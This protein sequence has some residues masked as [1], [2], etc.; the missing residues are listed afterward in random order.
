MNKSILLYGWFVLAAVVL[1]GSAGSNPAYAQAAGEGEN[2][3]QQQRLIDEKL[4]K[5]RKELA[6]VNSLLDWQWGGWLEYYIFHFDDGIQ[7]QRVYQ[8]PGLS[9]WTRLNVDNGAHQFFVRMKFNFEYFNPG[10]EYKRQQDWIGPNLDRG[11]YQID[12]GKAFRLTQPDDPF[13][14][15]VRIGRQDVMFGTGY[16]LDLPLDAVRFD[17]KLRDLTI[18]GLFAKTIGSYPN[19]D[20]SDPVD[21][22]SARRIFGVQA[23]YTGLQNHT[24]FGYALWNDDYTDERPTDW[25]QNY[26]YDTQYYGVG[27]RGT[28]VH[29]LNYWNEWVYEA[30]HS[31]GDGMVLRRDTVDA[32][33]W[34]AG[35]EYLFD[36]R[37][38]PYINFEYMFASGDPGRLFSPTSAAGGNRGDR[39]DT[40]FAGF[41]YR[42]TGI[43]A[44]PTLSNIHV[45]RLGGGFKPFDTTAFFRDL[46]LGT[47]WFLYHK[48]HT[49]GAI[50]DPTAG[51]FNGFVGWEMDYFINWRLASDIS[52]TMRW[53]AFFPGEAYMDREMRNFLFTGIT[54]SF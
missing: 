20:R 6:P 2:L 47:N 23:A 3:L 5:E 9:L 46:E 31:Y 21:S 35:L 26:S 13:Q 8:R 37:M 38:H 45:W 41:G 33:A 19:I 36:C 34:D 7:S 54:W 28:I 1:A 53:G 4:D 29:N 24:L 42:D 16:V 50:S 39:L 40:G 44:A 10:D 43:S 25:R 15:N 18:T 51:Q 49:R 32:W 48:H 27:A 30:G 12:V 22:H 14:M 52:W 17:A 11:W